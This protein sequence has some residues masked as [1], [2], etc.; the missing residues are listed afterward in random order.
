MSNF[1]LIIFIQGTISFDK[2]S[3]LLGTVAI[4]VYLILGGN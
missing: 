1:F 4:L 3:G 2:K